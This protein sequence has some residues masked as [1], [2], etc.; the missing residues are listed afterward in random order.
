[1]E[2]IGNGAFGSVN[3]ATYKNSLCAA[4]L[5]TPLALQLATESVFKIDSEKNQEA[6]QK[7][8]QKECHYLKFLVHKNVVRHL[9]TVVEPKS[10]LPILVMELLD[11]NLHQYLQR[12][13]PNFSFLNQKSLC[14]DI[15][16]GLAFLQSK[17][18]I[19]RD[20]CDDNILLELAGNIPTAKIS[21]IG[22]STILPHC[23]R[24]VYLPPEAAQDSSHYSYPLDVYSFGVIATQ[25]IHVKAQINSKKELTSLL[26]NIPETHHSFKIIICSC[27]SEDPK[28]RPQ[29]ANIVRKSVTVRFH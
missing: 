29:A 18:I 15:A 20:L 19:H 4:K 25:I 5:L 26:S 21:G 7:S 2:N 24:Q 28:S 1:M 3:K 12:D 11:C 22:M 23:H 14:L 8:L 27:L 9:A 17:K 13:L 10:K 16:E 6:T